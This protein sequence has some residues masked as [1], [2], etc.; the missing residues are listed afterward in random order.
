MPSRAKV[1][2]RNGWL[3]VGG[4]SGVALEEVGLAV[5]SMEVGL[6]DDDEVVVVVAGDLISVFHFSINFFDRNWM[7]SFSIFLREWTT[8]AIFVFYIKRLVGKTSNLMLLEG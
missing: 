8:L 4:V 2:S 6:E 7:L 3:G 1:R 5:I